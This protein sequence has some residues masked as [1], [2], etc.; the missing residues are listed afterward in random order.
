MLLKGYKFE[1]DRHSLTGWNKTRLIVFDIVV[2]M[3]NG[4]LYC[5]R[6][7]RTLGKSETANPVV[8]RQE[9]SLKV[10]KTILKVKIKWVHDCLGLLS[11]DATCKIAAQLG[12]KLSRTTFQ[13]YEA[14]AIGK[15]KQCN[16]PKEALGEK[17]TIFN[18]RVGHD[19]SKIKILEGMEVTINKSNWHIMVDKATGFKRSSFFETKDGII[20]YMCKMMHSK[21]L[22]GH[23][24]QVLHQDNAGENVKLV[25]MAKGKD[26]K[27]D[28][29]VK[30]TAREK[31][32]QNLHA[33]T[34]FT[35]I[36][37]QARCTLIAGHIP[38]DEQFKLWPEAVKTATHLN[39]LMPVTIEGVTQT[40][41]EHAGY[42]VH[43]TKTLQMFG[44]TGII[45]DGKKGKV[46][47]RQLTMMFVGYSEDHANSVFQ[48][49]NHVAS[50]IAQ[51]R[52]VIWMGRMF[53]TRRDA[54]LTQQQSIVTVPISI[55]NKSV[56]TEIQ[57]LGIATF[58]L[59]EERGVHSN[60]PSEKTDE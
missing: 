26:W 1:G 40:C 27:L 12:T 15:A 17:A 21:A 54:D 56:D 23:P 5:A 28:F 16:I 8:Q 9:G 32:Q 35:I 45:K 30:Y 41:W 3:Q 24:I 2:C 18:G 19:L 13:I 52:D 47:N 59:S 57:R 34:L 46:L 49:Y 33:K 20:D 50:R 6:L 36:A 31:P 22:R 29:T 10:A 11:K 55:H 25:K 4:A 14:C 51:T 43:N 39:N 48:M 44:E 58:P 37:A 7:T 60:S 38:D 53:H 42:K